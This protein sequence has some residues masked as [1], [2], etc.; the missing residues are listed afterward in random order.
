MLSWPG[1]VLGSTSGLLVGLA[2]SPVAGVAVTGLVTIAA[3]VLSVGADNEEM[4]SARWRYF[5]NY[6]ICFCACFA[7]FAALGFAIRLTQ[8]KPADKL[9][10]KLQ[11]LHVPDLEIAKYLVEATGKSSSPGSFLGTGIFYGS[12]TL[13][14]GKNESKLSPELGVV[15]AKLV[16]TPWSDEAKSAL[17][18]STD[19]RLKAAASTIQF[20]ADRQVAG[21]DLSMV[22]SKLG[23]MIC[24]QGSWATR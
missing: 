20:L 18:N 2:T 22:Q 10:A 24:G 15:C 9:V 4:L 3:S 11:E 13:E 21:S 23:V 8:P 16:S 7:L 6:A 12:S 5:G 19:E 14:K 1:M 17:S